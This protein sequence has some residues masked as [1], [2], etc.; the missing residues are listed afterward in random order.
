MRDRGDLEAGSVSFTPNV[1]DLVFIIFLVLGSIL[2][3]LVIGI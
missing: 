1:W 3:A 2:L